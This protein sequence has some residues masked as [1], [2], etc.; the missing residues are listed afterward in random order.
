MSTTWIAR[1]A[2]EL[3]TWVCVGSRLQ[4]P[5]PCRCVRT[6]RGRQLWCQRGPRRPRSRRSSRSCPRAS[7]CARTCCS[8]RFFLAARPRQAAPPAD[9]V[10]AARLLS[11][12]AAARRRRRDGRGGGG[13]G[14]GGA[15]QA[16]RSCQNFRAPAAR[17]FSARLR[18]A[19]AAREASHSGRVCESVSGVRGAQK[20][21]FAFGRDG[22]RGVAGGQTFL[23]QKWIDLDETNTTVGYAGGR[24]RCRSRKSSHVGRTFACRSKKIGDLAPCTHS[25]PEIAGG[26]AY[27][28]DRR[29]EPGLDQALEAFFSFRIE[30]MASS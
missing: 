17:R 16:S 20:C 14:G 3:T 12:A 27:Q 29:S 10:R 1:S 25:T 7:R 26:S 24:R 15:G 9:A 11:Q 13:G 6:C 18:R 2:P 5:H 28:M 4:G 8:S 23:L 30:P 21:A 19:W 22:V